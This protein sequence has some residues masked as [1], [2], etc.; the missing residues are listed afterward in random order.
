MAQ[1]APTSECEPKSEDLRLAFAFIANAGKRVDVLALYALLETLRDIPA[2]VTEPLMGEIRLRWW[3][4]AF[5]EIRDGKTPRYHP[6]TEAVRGLIGRHGLAIQDFLDLVEG[7]MPLLNKPLS[8]RDAMMAIDAGEGIIGRLAVRILD[9]EADP[10]SV[11]QCARLAGLVSLRASGAFA[12]EDFGPT[13]MAH[14]LTDARASVQ[15]LPADLMPLALPAVLAQDVWQG[16]AR[17]PL[18]KRFKLLWAFLTGRI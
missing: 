14:M 7:Q 16:R 13:E 18:A 12:R 17:N 9:P 4:E 1:A 10:V 3:F 15:G 8:L 5:E 2:R 11:L 6:L